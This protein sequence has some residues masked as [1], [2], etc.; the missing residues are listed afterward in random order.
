MS[1]H[2]RSYFS[3]LSLSCAPSD[4]PGCV[5]ACALRW[6]LFQF[7]NH[8]F[9]FSLLLVLDLPC[10]HKSLFLLHRS[11][12]F[13]YTFKN[14]HFKKIAVIY[15][16]HLPSDL[17][18]GAGGLDTACGILVPRPGIRPIPPALE[19]QSLNHWTARE[20]PILTV[21][22]YTV[23]WHWVYSITV[24]PSPY[25]FES[26]SLGYTS[27]IE[28]PGSQSNSILFSTMAAPF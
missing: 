22:K 10:L 17:F 1:P 20:I 9:F 25:L 2:S 12:S 4:F 19:A 3:S 21:L 28:I 15:T 16:E 27:Q 18:W 7:N 26:P 14:L 13:S 8:T 23:Q 11:C 24:Q 5:L 6:L